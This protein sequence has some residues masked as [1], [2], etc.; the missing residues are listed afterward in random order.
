MRRRPC[1]LGH[2]DRNSGHGD[3]SSHGW[4]PVEIF[5]IGA[6]RLYV[7]VTAV[8]LERNRAS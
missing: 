7:A 4:F 3:E 8:G 6:V 1:T 5:P 2:M